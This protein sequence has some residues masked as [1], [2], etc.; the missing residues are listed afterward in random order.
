MRIHGKYLDVLVDNNLRWKKHII[1]LHNKI[2][3][4]VYKLYK[5]ENPDL[6]IINDLKVVFTNL[7]QSI[8][9]CNIVSFDGPF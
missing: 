4:F 2:Q 1:F 5:L 9:Q 7:I 6:K 3:F 8:L